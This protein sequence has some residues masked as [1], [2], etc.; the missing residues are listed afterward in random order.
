VTTT[1]SPPIRL[2]AIVG[3]LAAIGLG[4]LLFAHNRSASSS[5]GATPSITRPTTTPTGAHVTP[6]S[7]PAV[8]P[9]RPRI[10]LLPNLPQPVAHAL[11]NSKVVVVVLFSHGATGDGSAVS[12]ARAGAKSAHSGFTAINVVNEKIA[13]VLGTFTGATTA[14]PAVLI[15]KRPG[16]IVNQFSGYADSAIIA[17]AALNAGAGR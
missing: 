2:L 8:K 3:V 5:T 14:P 16:K 9:A 13:R 7:K 4:V 15:V 17:Q 6:T 12:Q 1:L 10:A 11:R